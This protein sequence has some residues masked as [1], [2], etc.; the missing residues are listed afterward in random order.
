MTVAASH[1]LTAATC[2]VACTPSSARANVPTFDG[3][4]Y[5]AMIHPNAA[6]DL[7]SETGEIGWRAPQVYGASQAADRQR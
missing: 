4:M 3:G 7:K 5:V 6:Y 2:S 1:V